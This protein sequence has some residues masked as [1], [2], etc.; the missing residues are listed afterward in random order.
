MTEEDPTS[1]TILLVEDEALIRV[2]LSDYLQECGYKTVEAATAD[3]AKLIIETSEITID[4]VFTD[5]MMPGS[6]D[7]F[8]LARWIR[9]NHPAL[10][11]IITSGDAR[12]VAAAKDLCTSEPFIEKPYDLKRVVERIR[13]AIDSARPDG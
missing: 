4:L 11:V 5:V 9:E 13:A 2:T 7:G 1:S 8:G 3:E 10:P 12:K 6:M